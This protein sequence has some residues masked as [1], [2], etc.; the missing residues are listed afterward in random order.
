[1]SRMR[2]TILAH[3]RRLPRI[4]LL[5]PTQVPVDRTVLKDSLT[6]DANLFDRSVDADKSQKPEE[7]FSAAE[8]LEPVADT[9]KTASYSPEPENNADTQTHVAP[10]VAQPTTPTGKSTTGKSTTQ[11]FNGNATAT[12]TTPTTTGRSAATERTTPNQRPAA[13]SVTAVTA[14]PVATPQL[15]PL[16][17]D[18]TSTQNQCCQISSSNEQYPAHSRAAKWRR[19]IIGC[20]QDSRTF[21]K[22][23]KSG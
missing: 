12:K 8:S 9:V 22:H 21:R 5:S 20:S 18:P 3:Q 6:D 15:A 16:P 13:S 10:T 14:A 2:Q 7:A 1:M 19:K 23:D 11:F 4:L 17:V